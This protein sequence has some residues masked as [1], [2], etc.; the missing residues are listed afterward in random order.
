V[1]NADITG[2]SI[3]IE[4]DNRAKLEA[5][6]D[7]EATVAG[8][9]TL[10]DGTQLAVNAVI[11]SNTVLGGALAQ[12][13]NSELTATTGDVSVTAANALELSATNANQVS[14]GD[15][16]VGAMLAFNTLGY[17]SQNILF[18]TLDALVGTEIGDKD[19]S[20]AEALLTNTNVTAAGGVT[21][22]ATNESVLTA[23]FNNSLASSASGFTGQNSMAASVVLASNMVASGA[24]AAVESTAPVIDAQGGVSVSASDSSE[25]SSATTVSLL[26]ETVSDNEFS[27]DD[28]MALG[29]LIARNVLEGGVTAVIDHATVT[30]GSITLAA[31]NETTLTASID[32][33]ASASGGS[34]LG[35]GTQLAVSG[36]I[37]SNSVLGGALAQASDSSLT[38]ET[39]GVSVTADNSVNLTAENANQVTSGDTGAGVMLAFNT[40]GYES[41]N[42]LFQTLDAL[43]GSEIGDQEPSRADALVTNTNVT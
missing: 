25:L 39:G 30:G 28:S 27:D 16:G 21:V 9:S 4:A 3:S 12:G 43:I 6:V 18:Q 7:A 35:D 19:A 24:R 11:A 22:S 13:V 26:A 32:A 2:S 34:T 8:G 33:E 23:E 31:D 42:V 36:V 38:A 14:S 5:T 40:L 17:E 41:Q 1:F 20:T 37:A 10:G 29:A 15:T